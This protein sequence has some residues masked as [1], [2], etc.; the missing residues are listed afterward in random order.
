MADCARDARAW[1]FDAALPRW[2]DGG[3]NAP[4]GFF[5]ESLD[6]Q[7]QPSSSPH[8]VRVQ[9]RQTYVFMEAGRLGWSG[10][11]RD[12]A[13]A[14]LSTLLGPARA[15]GGAAGHLIDAHGQ[16]IDSR[17]DLYDQ[18]FSLFGLAHARSL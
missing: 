6:L 4:S 16:L 15:E 14:G 8:R 12:L 9:A 5:V 3:F 18:A 2:S 11:W 17:R 13:S 7:G 1:L 10:P